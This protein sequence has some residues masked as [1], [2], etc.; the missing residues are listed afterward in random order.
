MGKLSWDG[1]RRALQACYPQKLGFEAAGCTQRPAPEGLAE[2]GFGSH[3]VDMY[4][5]RWAQALC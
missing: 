1:G 2:A 5:D 3:A 4:G